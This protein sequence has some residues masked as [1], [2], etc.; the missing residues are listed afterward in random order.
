MTI[1]SKAEK[2]VLSLIEIDEEIQDLQDLLKLT[3]KEHTKDLVLL[4]I[5]KLKKDR[6]NFLPRSIDEAIEM[7]KIREQNY[8]TNRN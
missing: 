2:K 3:T 5:Y 7:G 4:R 8:G 1:K 6:I